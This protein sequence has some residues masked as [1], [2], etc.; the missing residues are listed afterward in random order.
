M[1][2]E[3]TSDRTLILHLD[4]VLPVDESNSI[5]R[6]G[7]IVVDGD[8]LA[9][10]GPTEAVLQEFPLA[11]FQTVID[12]NRM[13]AVPGFVDSHVHLHETLARGQ[14]SDAMETRSAIF[15]GIMPF[16]GAMTAADEEVSVTVGL[17]E[18]L[19]SGTT[20]FV[21]MGTMY[22]TGIAARAAAE[23]GM[24][25]IVGHQAA[26]V[27]PDPIPS[28]WS[29]AVIER[30]F[31]WPD[32]ASTLEA[33]REIVIQW[34]G[35]A[36]G[37]IRCWMTLQGKEPCSLELHLGAREIAQDLNVGTT[38]HIS[39]TLKEAEMSRELYGQ[40]PVARLAA[41]GG[42]GSNS[43]LAHATA[44]TDEEVDLVAEYDAK[45]G[46]CPG[47][48]FKTAKGATAI[49]K[50]PE[51]LA[52]GVTVGLGTDGALFSGSLNLH[53]MAYVAAGMF[54][55]ARMDHTLVG[56]E[57]ALRMIT[58]DGARALQWDD[59]IGSLEAGK[60]ADFLLFD[61]RHPEWQPHG[62]PV[63]SLIWSATS[64]SL[65]ET[66]VNGVPLYRNGEILGFSGIDELYREAQARADAIVKRAGLGGGALRGSTVYE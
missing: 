30:H 12:G 18:M 64:A 25:G 50:F 1:P 19:R 8:R 47:T 57:K 4:F 32:T 3:P 22:D 29:D 33:L 13:G 40:T 34:N 53:K 65:A 14:L 52:A 15:L 28:A 42:L 23:L 20:C 17:L 5:I 36:D 59:E 41:H 60:K 62:D 58:I 37:R 27:V 48:A 43:L 44:L 39:T 26:D 46:F 2:D 54:K 63:Q 10:V 6:D 7:A 31:Q 49:G 38:F 66:W 55:D 51:M 11:G 16:Y 45:I 56:A 24:R 21:D 35:Y 61:L 9:A